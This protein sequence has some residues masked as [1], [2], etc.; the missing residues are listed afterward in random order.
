LQPPKGGE[1][2]RYIKLTAADEE[3]TTVTQLTKP[4]TRLRA[5]KPTEGETVI[6]VHLKNLKPKK[7]WGSASPIKDETRGA[8]DCLFAGSE[9]SPEALFL[10]SPPVLRGRG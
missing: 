10:P 8:V 1:P 2:I 6:A 5:C 7:P 9:P 4:L 3:K